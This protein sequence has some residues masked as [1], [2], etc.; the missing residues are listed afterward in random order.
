MHFQKLYM[1]PSGPGAE[2]DRLLIISKNFSWLRVYSLSGMGQEWLSM[3]LFRC[4]WL[5]GF[6]RK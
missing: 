2:S 3:I 5:T 1:I 6:S 4:F